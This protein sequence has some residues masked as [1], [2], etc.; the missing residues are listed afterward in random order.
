MNGPNKENKLEFHITQGW[1]G[2]SVTNTL[3]YWAYSKVKKKM[4]E[5]NKLE[6]NTTQ[7]WKGLPMTNILAYWTHS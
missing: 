2:L 7:G 6:C 3:A 5:P 4:N 1:K